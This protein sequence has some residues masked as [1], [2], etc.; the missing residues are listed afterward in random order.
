MKNSK[1]ILQLT[2]VSQPNIAM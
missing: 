1:K 2:A